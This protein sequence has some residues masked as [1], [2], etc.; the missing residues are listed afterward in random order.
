MKIKRSIICFL[1][2][3]TAVCAFSLP[4][5]AAED[6]NL[7]SAFWSATGD[8]RE[9]SALKVTVTGEGGY[10]ALDQNLTG[11]YSVEFTV[12]NLAPWVQ[13][14]GK[15]VS[16]DGE[17]AFFFT[18]G[19]KK[20]GDRFME[21]VGDAGAGGLSMRVTDSMIHTPVYIG[22]TFPYYTKDGESLG[23]GFGH[24]FPSGDWA[25]NYDLPV[26]YRFDV[27]RANTRV[28]IYCDLLTEGAD[29]SQY[30]ER[31]YIS[32]TQLDKLEGCPMLHVS[33]STLVDD[34]IVRDGAGEEIFAET[35]D[36]GE[37]SEELKTDMLPSMLEIVNESSLMK[38]GSSLA[39][40]FSLRRRP[41]ED[42]RLLDATFFVQGGADDSLKLAF[43][44]ASVELAEGKATFFD[45]ESVAAERASAGLSLTRGTW[46]RLT[47]DDEGN[48]TL[49]K[50]LRSVNLPVS[51]S[52]SE[53]ILSHVYDP[54]RLEGAVSILPAVAADGELE[55]ADFS[56]IA[57][58]FDAQA[59]VGGVTVDEGSLAYVRE[60]GSVL[61]LSAEVSLS[62]A[63]DAH[64]GVFWQ[65]IS[66][67]GAVCD[68]DG[69]DNPLGEYLRVDGYG[70]IVIRAV[71]AYDPAVSQTVSVHVIK[72]RQVFVEA[73]KLS[74]EEY[75]LS[76]K[77]DLLPQIEN[78]GDVK[79]QVI[80][81][82][83]TVTADGKLTVNGRKDRVVVKA[84]SEYDPSVSAEYVVL[85]ARDGN[86]A[87]YIALSCVFG[88]IAL[89]SI[90]ALCCIFWFAKKRKNP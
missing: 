76:A 52:P 87:L 41:S 48:A 29:H 4:V 60:I 67:S 37:M 38:A 90:G 33:S 50:V 89:A 26:R 57:G 31:A 9:E 39:G 51:V 22:G 12:K 36:S 63:L 61:P 46:V 56:V 21:L 16:S 73:K 3:A 6:F 53:E 43:G 74:S 70:T 58:M 30:T 62:P 45:G 24:W 72:V 28:R 34:F 40:N 13:K 77:V 83:A 10:L 64:K 75:A 80:E 14:D 11:D 71:S 23:D 69:A 55:I 42:G 35:F 54:A 2:I 44:G 5:S 78:Y 15:W 65:V 86:V 84:V 32:I 66:G 49:S 20:S 17:G 19:G 7:K 59:E 79:W 88:A 25:R 8:V 1:V 68:R 47:L 18:L 81:G 85:Q 82:D 27:D